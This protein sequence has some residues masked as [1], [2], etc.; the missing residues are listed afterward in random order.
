M[1]ASSHKLKLILVCRGVHLSINNPDN[2]SSGDY[3]FTRSQDGQKT[4]WAFKKDWPA[5]QAHDEGAQQILVEAE[6]KCSQIME[7]E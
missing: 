7:C 6:S 4:I 2:V 1:L 5:K 3:K